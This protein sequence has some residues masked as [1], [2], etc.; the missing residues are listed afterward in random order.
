MKKQKPQPLKIGEISTAPDGEKVQCIASQE[1]NWCEKC[2]FIRQ[3]C[4]FETVHRFSCTPSKR[5]D[6]QNVYFKKV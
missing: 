2:H 3:T 1:I 5:D 6:L 4:N